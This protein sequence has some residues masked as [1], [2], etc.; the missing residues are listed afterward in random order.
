VNMKLEW[1]MWMLIEKALEI[2]IRIH[3][4]QTDKSGSRSY[5]EHPLAVMSLLGHNASIEE[6][7]VAILHDAVEDCK[8]SEQRK[9]LLEI[10]ENFGFDVMLAINALT[11]R[12]SV[13]YMEYIT[14]CVAKNAISTKVKICDILH[15]TSIERYKD[16]EGE[17]L[18]KFLE[19]IKTKYIPAIIFLHKKMEAW[20]RI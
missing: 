3:A 10:E 11:H 19:K 20:K 17:D 1:R 7:V 6:K 4:G 16:L 14:E 15:N 9:L 18:T 12:L 13:P 8:K 5:I 2:A